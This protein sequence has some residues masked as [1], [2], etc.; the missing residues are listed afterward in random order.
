MDTETTNLANMIRATL[1]YNT[2][3]PAP[4]AGIPAFAVAKNAA[5]NKLVLIDSLNQVAEGDSKGVTLDTNAIRKAM[6]DLGFK[7]GSAVSAYAASV[8][9]NTLRQRVTYTETALIRLSKEDVDDVCQTIHDEANA[10]IAAAGAFG[11]AAADVTD[12]QTS[13]DLYRLSVQNP[14]QSIISK[15]QAIANIKLLARETIDDLFKKQ[16][17]KMV[18]TLK[19][20]DRNFHDG[21]FLAR[22]IINLGSTTAKVR[23]TVKD[24]DDV[25]LVGVT[26]IIRKSATGELVGQTN[27]A[28][29]GSFS[30]ASLLP[31]DYDFTWSFPSY[32]TLTEANVHIS[33]GKELKRTITLLKLVA[34][35]PATSLV[36]DGKITNN[37]TG[38][39]IVN[40]SVSFN[41]IGSPGPGASVN[42][43]ASGNY[44][45]QGDG[46][47]ANAPIVIHHKVEAPGFLTQEK[48]ISMTTGQK[49]I[50]DVV[51][52]PV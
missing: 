36:I 30:I 21:Y 35:I 29:N 26:F 23:G 15:T 1:S 45:F 28:V 17:D 34:T 32:Q 38:L 20:T 9:N 44:H 46:L 42:T 19:I 6:T 10:N 49:F 33:A 37:A 24:K 52:N 51:M 11:Y 5:Q 22:E 31:G 12:L 25:P 13:I 4:T 27:T 16:M 50:I 43:D 3:N 2:N 41:A 48:D 7:C 47:D 40:A 18:S 39:G 8:N 14:R